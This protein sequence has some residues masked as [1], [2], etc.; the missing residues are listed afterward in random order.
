M[1]R[2]RRIARSVNRKPIDSCAS[3]FVENAQV[4]GVPLGLG[5]ASDVFRSS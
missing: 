1:S 5:P 4:L 2:L 3:K